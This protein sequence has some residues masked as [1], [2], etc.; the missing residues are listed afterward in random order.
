MSTGK[1][2]RRARR[3]KKPERLLIEYV[4]G[5]C[6]KCLKNKEKKTLRETSLLLG[7]T[8]DGAQSKLKKILEKLRKALRD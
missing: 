8:E 5:I 4:Y 7:L 2:D 3:V 6:P 1:T